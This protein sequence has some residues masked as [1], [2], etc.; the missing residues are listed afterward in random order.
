MR[1]NKPKQYTDRVE[2]MLKCYD[3]Q[4]VMV[5]SR[6]DVKWFVYHHRK[7]ICRNMAADYGASKVVYITPERDPLWG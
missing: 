6:P 7:L 2:Q 4:N 3:R 5:E 1:K